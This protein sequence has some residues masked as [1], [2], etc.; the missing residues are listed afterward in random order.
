MHL[1]LDRWPGNA[2]DV[3]ISGGEE[4]LL[5]AFGDPRDDAGK[6]S[7]L[8]ITVIIK[9]GLS[10]ICSWVEISFICLSG[11]DSPVKNSDCRNL[12]AGLPYRIF[13]KQ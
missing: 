8:R 11:T 2:N 3:M 7:I 1:G 6:R 4:T 9:R 13:D 12:M 5:C 10:V